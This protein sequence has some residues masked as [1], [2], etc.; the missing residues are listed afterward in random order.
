[1][2][3]FTSLLNRLGF[4]VKYGFSICL[5]LLERILKSICSC[6]RL[7]ENMYFQVHNVPTAV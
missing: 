5:H 7:K 1:M 3:G 4:L 2:I 6:S